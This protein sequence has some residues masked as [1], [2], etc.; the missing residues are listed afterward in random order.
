[1]LG[2]ILMREEAVST[3]RERTV[4]AAYVGTA[5]ALR[6]VQDDPET[7]AALEALQTALADG[8]TAGVASKLAALQSAIAPIDTDHPARKHAA[9]V[10][11]INVAAV[12]EGLQGEPKANPAP[13]EDATDGS[14][15]AWSVKDLRAECARLGLLTRGRKA[16]LI[17][18]LRN[19]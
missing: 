18:A 1:M 3:P 16:A 11:S 6:Q 4:W 9:R 7:L 2:A 5:V 13:S 17:D 19:A 14:Y 12:I 8:K 15:D 10:A